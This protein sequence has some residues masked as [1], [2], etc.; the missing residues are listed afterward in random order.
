MRTNTRNA[1]ATQAQK[2]ILDGREADAARTRKSRSAQV[3]SPKNPTTWCGRDDFIKA[4][5]ASDLPD[6]MVRVLVRL[7]MHLNIKHGRLDPSC[8]RLAETSNVSERTVYRI[9][10]RA[11]AE[12]LI[13]ID[14]SNGSNN[15]YVL[16]TTAIHMAVVTPAKEPLP[17]GAGTTATRLAVK[18]RRQAK[19]AD[20]RSAGM[21]RCFLP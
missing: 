11:E 8:K 17:N 14:R 20:T 18:K 21:G 3:R 13:A 16:L 6:K 7:A 9:L 12:G 19:K 15:Q 5:L 1:S 10:E 4:I 2:P